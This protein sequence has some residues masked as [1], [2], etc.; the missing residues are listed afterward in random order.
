[1][2]AADIEKQNRVIG[3]TFLSSRFEKY[4]DFRIFIVLFVSSFCCRKNPVICK[5]FQRLKY[6][7]NPKFELFE[8]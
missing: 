7:K 5:N 4:I 1:M 6:N 8:R 2:T 3:F